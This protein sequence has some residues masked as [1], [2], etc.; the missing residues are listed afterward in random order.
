MDKYL[1][2]LLFSY[3]D[4]D[5]VDILPLCDA[6][7][8]SDADANADADDDNDNDDDGDEEELLLLTY[9]DIESFVSVSLDKRESYELS[10]SERTEDVTA[11]SDRKDN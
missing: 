5:D 8:V 10:L 11:L 3:G 7:S 4:V 9:G 2:N 1:W 6:S